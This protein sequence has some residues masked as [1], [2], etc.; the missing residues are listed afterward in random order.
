MSWTTRRRGNPVVVQWPVHVLDN[1]LVLGV[2]DG[3]LLAE[4]KV[5]KLLQNIIMQTGQLCTVRTLLLLLL[6][7]LV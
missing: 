3:I 1:P 7:A 5:E 4:E 6:L 2:E